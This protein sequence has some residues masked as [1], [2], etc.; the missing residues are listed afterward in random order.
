MSKIYKELISDL[1]IIL[2]NKNKN[3]KFKNLFS[4]I[5]KQEY[6]KIN[7][8]VQD[9][10]ISIIINKIVIEWKR[11]GNN[12]DNIFNDLVKLNE[13]LVKFGEN[14]QPSKT[15][16]LKFLKKNIFINIY[17]LE[18]G[19]YELKTTKN[20]LINSLRNKPELRYPLNIAKKYKTLKWFLVNI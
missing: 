13:L 8:I 3:I 9:E 19:E 17:H 5:K 10:T 12:L 6:D 2:I 4:L 20:E 11:I 7:E 15:Q 14:P 1:K 16:A 18:A